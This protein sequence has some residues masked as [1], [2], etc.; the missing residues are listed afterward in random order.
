LKS[1]EDAYGFAA[2]DEPIQVVNARLVARGVPDRP[3]LP[4][5]DTRVGDAKAALLGHRPVDF[6]EPDGSLDCPVYD[7]ARLGAGDRLDGPAVIEQFDSTTLLYPGQALE[8]DARGL[9]VVTEGRA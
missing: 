6:S 3:R 9:L 7:R 5:Q 1:H 8:V 2:E 4:R